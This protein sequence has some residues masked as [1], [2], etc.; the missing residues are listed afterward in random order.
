[1]NK[2]LK[3]AINLSLILFPWGIRRWVFQKLFGFVFEENSYIGRSIV[4]AN[5]LVLKKGAVIKSLN[6]INEIDEIELGPHS[7]IDSRNWITGLSTK[8]K[9]NFT[10]DTGRECYLRLAEHA[11]ITNLHFLDCTG[12]ISIGKFTTVAG[13]RSVLLTHG[14]DLEISRQRSAPLS[15]GAYCFVGTNCKL[16]MGAVLPDRSMLAA[17]AVLATCLSDECY[18]YGGVPAKP[19]KALEPGFKY[20]SRNHGHVN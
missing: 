10:Y 1:M 20:F 8:Y 4:L 17:G 7:Q 6:F 9:H 12:G 2:R 18:L 5:K 15:I 16:L 13:I 19:V 3:L 14:I 11:R